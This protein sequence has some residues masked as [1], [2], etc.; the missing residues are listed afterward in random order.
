[1]FLDYIRWPVPSDPYLIVEQWVG[2]ASR[3]MRHLDY[4]SILKLV[5]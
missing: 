3:S 4:V 5:F 1:M 2:V